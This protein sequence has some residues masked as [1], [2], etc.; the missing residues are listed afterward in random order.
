MLSS[1][2][3]HPTPPLGQAKQIPN[4]AGL[5]DLHGHETLEHFVQMIALREKSKAKRDSL[6]PLAPNELPAPASF[7]IL[8]RLAHRIFGA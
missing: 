1:A 2:C 4:M 3:S 5:P 8:K 6:P 7:P